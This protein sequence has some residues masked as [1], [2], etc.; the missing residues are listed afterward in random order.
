MNFRVIV[1]GALNA[2]SCFESRASRLLD[3][4]LMIIPNKT[5]AA[6]T[7]NDDFVMPMQMALRGWRLA[8]GD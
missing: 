4:S 7:I 5:V 1:N 8:A 6:D 3:K 2:E